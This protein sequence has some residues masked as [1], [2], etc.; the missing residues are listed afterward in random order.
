MKKYNDNF[1]KAKNEESLNADS[2]LNSINEDLKNEDY[3]ELW[4]KYGKAITWGGICLIAASGIWSMWQRQDLSDR[5]ALSI[6][7]S[8]AQEGLSAGNSDKAMTILR[9][10]AK[11]SK[12]GYSTLA[13]FEYAAILR[14]KRDTKA[15]E[16]YK[17]IYLDKKVPRIYQNFAYICYVHSALD[18]M[19]EQELMT[20]LDEFARHLQAIAESSW[21]CLAIEC[22][23]FVLLKK[24]DIKQARAN[25]E[26]LA[27]LPEIPKAMLDRSRELL[28]YT[29]ETA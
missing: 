28:Q 26:T 3:Q 2:F 15:F 25:L 4:K 22:L 29:F 21:K 5:E 16:Q 14:E 13:K 17:N 12:L 24:G 11:S 6:Q 1:K 23:A 18:L 27:K 7:F 10:L 9:E 20:K 19:P 8:L